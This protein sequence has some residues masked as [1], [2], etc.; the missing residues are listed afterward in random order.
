MVV[1][2]LNVVSVPVRKAKT[3]TPL[4]VYPNAKLTLPISLQ[5]L[6]SVRRRY[7]QVIDASGVVEHLEFPL[8]NRLKGAEAFCQLAEVQ[9]LRVLATEG[10]D[11]G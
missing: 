2:D 9:S 5:G 8:S 6:Q 1:D 3:Q 10:L 7:A 4:I 11:H